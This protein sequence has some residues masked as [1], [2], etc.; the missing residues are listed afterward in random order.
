MNNPG[1]IALALIVVTAWGC[2]QEKHPAKNV[3]D[4]TPTE[5]IIR[6]VEVFKPID[7]HKELEM[8][9]DRLER[10]LVQLKSEVTGNDVSRT[11]THP[12]T[13]PAEATT[14]PARPPAP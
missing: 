2:T 4:Q 7:R 14:L 5:A 3:P 6:S 1:Q 9:V 10:E 12:T 11:A 8:R 13:L